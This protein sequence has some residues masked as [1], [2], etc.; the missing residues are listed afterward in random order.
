MFSHEPGKKYEDFDDIRSEIES[1]TD[2]IAGANKGIS[3]EPINLQIFSPHVLNLTLVDLPGITKIPIGDEQEDIEA[4]TKNLA[5]KYIR[6]ENCLIL[7][8]TPANVSLVISDAL[9][10]AHEVDPDG[11][12][13]IGVITKCDKMDEYGVDDTDLREVLE[14]KIFPLQRGY[15]GVVN[16]SQK[17]TNDKES[18]QAALKH[19]A[20]FFAN[21]EKLSDIAHRC[22][23]PYL[24]KVL[25]R[26]LTEHIRKSI[27]ALRE[28]LQIKISELNVV[29]DEFKN[30]QSQDPNEMKNLIIR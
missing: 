2:F 1:D 8:V 19:E 23:T 5:L 25:N 18:I 14:N 11:N 24:Q 7:A 17:A 21:H 9:Q 15:I 10:L 13:T 29:V 20:D 30:W 3:D 4:Q 16:R 22:G 12:R 26:E 28:E 27:P 6:K